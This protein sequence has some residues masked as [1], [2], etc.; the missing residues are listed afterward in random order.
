MV[1]VPAELVNGLKYGAVCVAPKGLADW[2][3]W[4]GAAWFPAE[5]TPNRL[6]DWPAV[7]EGKR[8]C[9]LPDGSRTGGWGFGNCVL[10][11]G[12]ATRVLS[13]DPA[14]EGLFPKKE[15]VP[16][17]LADDPKGLL[18]SG[19]VPD[20]ARPEGKLDWTGCMPAAPEAGAALSMLE[21][22]PSGLD[23]PNPVEE[24][25]DAEELKPGMG[26]FELIPVDCPIFIVPVLGPDAGA[27]PNPGGTGAVPKM[28]EP[29]PVK[30]VELTPDGIPIPVE[31]PD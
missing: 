6:P 31:G 18:E 15:D 10:N 26:A 19:A 24:N 14:L 11:K 7:P 17:L 21:L 30:G 3:N 1:E 8:F 22:E 20:G 13:L 5:E 16:M 28:L 9:E 12:G 23:A 25:G 2:P 4:C 27:V 29:P